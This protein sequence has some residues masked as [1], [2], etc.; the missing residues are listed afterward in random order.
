M[1]TIIR[2]EQGKI[3]IIG[4]DSDGHWDMCYQH[5]FGEDQCNCK[6]CCEACQDAD[7]G[8]AYEERMIAQGLGDEI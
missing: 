7:Y 5:I 1:A 6:L 3:W 4:V 2:K 8:A